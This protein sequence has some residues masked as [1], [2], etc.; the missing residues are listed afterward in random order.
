MRYA[1]ETVWCMSLLHCFYAHCAKNQNMLSFS[2]N[3]TE[4]E[5]LKKCQKIPK[6]CKGWSKKWNGTLILNW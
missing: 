3:L 5:D 6:I 2:K 1:E 4:L